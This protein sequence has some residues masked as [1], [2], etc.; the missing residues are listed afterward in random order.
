MSDVAYAGRYCTEDVDG[1][2]DASCF[3]GVECSDV[4]APGVGA[5]CGACPSGYSGDGTKCTG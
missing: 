4:A 3:E 2:S 1:C 5:T